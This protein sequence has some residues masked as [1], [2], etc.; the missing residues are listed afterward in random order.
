MH[1]KIYLETVIRTDVSMGSMYETPI[2]LVTSF[3]SEDVITAST[4]DVGGEFP[5]EWE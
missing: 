5:G 1:E 3:T 2:V 4:S